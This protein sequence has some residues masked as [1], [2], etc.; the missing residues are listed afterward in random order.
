MQTKACFDLDEDLVTEVIS[1]VEIARREGRERREKG[2]CDLCDD[3]M[4][5]LLLWVL[6]LC[7]SLWKI[8]SLAVVKNHIL[9]D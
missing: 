5:T 2:S 8:T 3:V 1:A 7:L 6:Q 4:L 9:H